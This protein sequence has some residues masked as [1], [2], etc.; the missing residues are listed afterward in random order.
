MTTRVKYRFWE[1]EEFQTGT[2]IRVWAST[3]FG[4][5]VHVDIKR[6]GYRETAVMPIDK[7]CNAANVQPI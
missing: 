2:I 3:V 4:Y 1:N 6:D 7:F 5:S